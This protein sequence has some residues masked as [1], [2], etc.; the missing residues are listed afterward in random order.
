VAIDIRFSSTFI[1][2]TDFS[3]N[4]IAMDTFDTIADL[5]ALVPEL[6]TRVR[7]LLAT[8]GASRQPEG[9]G[10]VVPGMV[11]AATGRVLNAPQ[12]GWRNVDV[13][14][15]L[16]E[17]LGLPVHVENAPI[18][19]ALARM[20]LGRPGAPVPT[21]FVYVTVSD[22]I[23]A[24]VVVNGQVVRG[25]TNSA[26]EFGH[27]PLTADG[28]TC[29]CGGHGCLEVYTSNLATVCRYL[30][31]EFSPETA[32][33]LLPSSGVTIAE[34]VA[35]AIAG[36]A[37]AVEALQ[38]TARHLG[39][40]LSVIIKT[41][42]PTQIVVGGEITEA[43]EQLEPTIRHEIGQRALTDMAAATPIVPELASTYP[44]LRGGTALV[45][46]P[47]FAAPKFA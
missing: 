47:L 6:Q 42:S 23:G 25:Q 5:R 2:L 7:R 13:R 19:C 26:G 28:P 31:K 41:L 46:A 45:S 14:S 36:E 20:W 24:G 1:M 15:P 16:E 34:V 3:G 17:A 44:R 21:D 22:G 12:L 33:A 32:R 4:S 37:R 18:A 10:L 39:A 11:D 27:V 35:R 9:V 40:G 38:V 29:L 8:H 30:G 43:W